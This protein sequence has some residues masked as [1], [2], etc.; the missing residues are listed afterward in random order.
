MDNDKL[1]ILKPR[2]ST[3]Q[4]DDADTSGKPFGLDKND[5]RDVNLQSEPSYGTGSVEPGPFASID[6]DLFKNTHCSYN[7]KVA[8]GRETNA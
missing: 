5:A 1:T 8:P 7:R 3:P 2:E 4:P 6:N